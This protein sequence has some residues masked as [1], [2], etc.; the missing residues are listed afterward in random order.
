MSERDPAGEE[1]DREEREGD[2]GDRVGGADAIEE[3][4]SRRA[5]VR[6]SARPMSDP[7]AAA[8]CPGG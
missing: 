8:T 6:A 2:E 4:F 5:P 7:I 3:L 1:G